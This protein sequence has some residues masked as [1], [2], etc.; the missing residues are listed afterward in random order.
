MQAADQQDIINQSI[1]TVAEAGQRQ[2]GGKW[3]ERETVRVA[4]HIREWDIIE[5]WPWADW[6]EREKRLPGTTNQDVAIGCVA[7]RR[8]DGEHIAI[9]CKSRQLDE[10][11]RG[12]PISKDEFDSF[13]SASADQSG[14]WTAKSVPLAVALGLPDKTG[15][16]HRPTAKR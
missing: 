9:Q 12:N 6:P 16:R 5:C 3:L 10:H 4:R 13:A 7:V 15:L 1:D 8:S 11:G 14:F 2:T